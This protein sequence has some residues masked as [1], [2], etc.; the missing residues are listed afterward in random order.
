MDI[1][2]LLFLQN[3]RHSIHDAWTPFME[4]ASL[5][6]ITYLIFIPVF[7]Y[8]CVNKRKGLYILASL[9]TCLAL[10]E[11]IKLTACVYRPWVRDPRIIPAGHA[12]STA[13][14]YSFPSGH[15]TAATPLY[16]GLAVVLWDKKITRWLSVL[17]VI[18]LLITGFS[19]NY[20]GV[21]TPQDVLVGWILGVLVLWAMARMFRYLTAHPDKENSF[22]LASFLGGL[23]AFVY[24]YYKPYPLDYVNGKLLV[25]P[26]RMTYDAYLFIGGF[27]ALCVSRY[28]EKRWVRFTQSGLTPRGIGWALAG[29]IPAYALLRLLPGWCNPLLGPHVGRLVCSAVQ[30]F[31]VIAFYPWIL[32][33]L[34]RPH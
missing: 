17:C 13:G 10:N 2:Y 6:A 11:L 12:I 21:H 20:L 15:T 16:G 9:Y 31:Y 3:F 23:L 34:M 33:H 27:M 26:Y 18:G 32:K 14:G 4:A 19:R 22:L 30:V 7:I 8:W 5:F 24:I 29:F 1:S 28:V 25:D